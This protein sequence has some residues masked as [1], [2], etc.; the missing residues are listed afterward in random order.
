MDAWERN[1]ANRM[2]RRVIIESPYA[3]DVERNLQYLRAAMRDCLMNHDEAPFASHG[4]YAQ[5]GVLDDSVP[6]E[7]AHG[8][9]AGFEWRAAA[10]ATIVYT[11]LGITGGMEMG[12]RH[13]SE[14]GIPVEYRKIPG[15]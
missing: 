13:A 7:R 8:I 4:L 14:H 6:S 11:D 15:W 10:D 9:S 1:G 5:D 12:I 3:G 2:M